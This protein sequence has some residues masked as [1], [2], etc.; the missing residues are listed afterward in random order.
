MQ[1]SEYIMSKQNKDGDYCPHV[2]GALVRF[3]GF[4]I[5]QRPESSKKPAAL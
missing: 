3:T 4:F 1:D 2:A 5:G